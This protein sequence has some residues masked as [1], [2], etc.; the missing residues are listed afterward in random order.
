MQSFHSGQARWRPS[1]VI[2]LVASRR[3]SPP[4]AR[5][6]RRNLP[7]PRPVRAQRL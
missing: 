1:A 4:P 5:L 7:A 2:R 3:R 6:R